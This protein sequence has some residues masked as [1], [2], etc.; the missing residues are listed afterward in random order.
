[1]ALLLALRRRPEAAWP[2]LLLIPV[3]AI[4]ALLWTAPAFARGSWMGSFVSNDGVA[5]VLWTVR[6][7]SLALALVLA[8]G[9]RLL[10][11]A[12]AMSAFA[13]DPVLNGYF[14]SIVNG[15]TL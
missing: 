13:A 1:L 4:T 15:L 10:V 12:V 9:R 6:L 2:L 5:Q 14:A 7:V 8:T 11:I 3:I